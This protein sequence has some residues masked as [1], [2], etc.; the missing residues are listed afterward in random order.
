MNRVFWQG[1]CYSDDNLYLPTKILVFRQNV[2]H[3]DK[4]PDIPTN[5]LTFRQLSWHSDRVPDIPT[6]AVSFRQNLGH[7]EKFRRI[8]W[9]S[10]RN[11]TFW[12]RIL[13]FWQK[14]WHSDKKTWHSDK[15]QA[16]QQFSKVWTLFKLWK[17]RQ[18]AYFSILYK[19]L[20]KSCIESWIFWHGDNLR[21][22]YSV[23]V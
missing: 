16:F 13:T 18:K 2:W 8:P 20:E 23:L 17:F 1:I 3:S 6:N 15:I 12:Q 14:H 10:D 21:F 5:I 9:H 4:C 22:L 11:L 7:S 19:I